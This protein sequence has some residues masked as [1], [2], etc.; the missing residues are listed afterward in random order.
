MRDHEPT[1]RSREL[2]YALAR[3]AEIRGLNGKQLAD[4][5]GW[6][7]SKISRLF[8]GRRG[9]STED[10]SALLAVCGIIGPKRAELLEI[11]RRAY[12]P[13][14]WQEYGDRLPLELRTLSDH[15]D[16]AIAITNFENVVVP[17]LLQTADYMRALMRVSPAIPAAEMD[18]R[19]EARLR[20]QDVFGRRPPARFRFFL[21]EY[22][23]T[24]T[25]PGREIMSEQVHHLLRMSVRTYLEVR[26]IPDAIGFHASRESFK[27]MEFTEFQPVVHIENQTSVL[28]LERGDTIAGYRKIVAHLDKVAL[29]EE[30][31]RAWLT[32]L[33]ARLG[34][35]REDHDEQPPLEEEFLQ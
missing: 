12:Q 10:V 16:A 24:R 14:W 3:A 18:E 32:A 31:S 11:A 21:D 25:G 1:V 5:L 22:A 30:H 2:G 13:G 28:F 23:L 26:I 4:L 9:A 6:S 34:E 7:P 33:A 19:V 29:D 8:R 17:G 15:E 20:R 35:P 27:L